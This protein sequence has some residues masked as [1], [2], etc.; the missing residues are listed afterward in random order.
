VN[1]FFFAFLKRL[2]GGLTPWCFRDADLA[3]F[4]FLAFL[5]MGQIPALLLFSFHRGTCS[6]SSVYS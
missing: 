1:H 4:A 5:A 2:G 6:D 3:F